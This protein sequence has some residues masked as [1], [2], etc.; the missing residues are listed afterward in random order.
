MKTYDI[1]IIGFGVTGMLLLA[2]LKKEQFQNIC[3]IDPYF[4]GGDLIRLWGD[5]LSNVPLQKTIDALKLI[6]PHYILH[7]DLYDPAK[8]TPLHFVSHMVKDFS[9]QFLQHVDIYESTVKKLDYKDLWTISSENET[10]QSKTILLCQGSEPKKIK[11]S[12]P[13]IPL[14]IALNKNLLKS[15]IKPTDKVLLFGTAHSGTLILENLEQLSVNTSAIYKGAKPFI[16]ATEDYDGIK[17]EAERIANEILNDKYNYIKLY[18]IHNVEKIIKASKEADWIINAI[19]FEARN[20]ETYVND[21]LV[22]L[23]MYDSK[24]GLLTQCPKAYGFGIAYPSLAPDNIHVDVG[25]YSFIEHIQK[26]I[27]NLKTILI[28]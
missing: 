13:C 15:Y 11:C 10:I 6:D 23:R 25:L 20:I 16:F 19:G 27:V 22:S 28:R 3:I 14:H 18:H 24:T 12:I 2:I 7:Q 9:K 5:V 4:D 8:I 26:Q 21:S 17:E 1:T